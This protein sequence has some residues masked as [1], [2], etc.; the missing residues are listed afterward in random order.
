MYCLKCQFK[1]TGTDHK[2]V[3]IKNG[4]RHALTAYCEKCGTKM[5]KILSKQELLQYDMV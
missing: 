3:L 2:V 5:Y 4:Q 1:R